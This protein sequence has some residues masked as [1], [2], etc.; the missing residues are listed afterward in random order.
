MQ[1]A[2]FLNDAEKLELTEILRRDSDSG[3]NE[4]FNWKGVRDALTDWQCWGYAML[5]HTHSFS[6]Y[7]ITLFSP[8]IIQGLGYKSWQAQLLSTPPYAVAFIA[9]MAI[10]FASYRFERRGIFI[11]G[12]DIFAI[13]GYIILISDTRAGPSYVGL[14]FV[15]AGVYAANALVLSWP[16]ENVSS[17][18]KRATALGMQ[19]SI[20]NCGAITSVL[21]YVSWAFAPL[22]A[23]S[24]SKESDE[25][26][27]PS[28]RLATHASLLRSAP[29][30][31]T[32]HHHARLPRRSHRHCGPAVDLFGPCQ[33]A[34]RR[35]RGQ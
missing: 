22:I 18:T 25:R 31:E 20:G 34:A 29:L 10:A 17:Q 28:F 3:D 12:G 8:T 9:V 5:F 6:L 30:Q 2:R 7:S 27:F 13:I 4:A 24:T 32:A 11:I 23:S 26:P 19:I 15:I 14:F 16:A 21:I 1:K 35:T 33:Q